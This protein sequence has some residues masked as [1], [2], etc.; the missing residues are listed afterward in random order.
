MHIAQ[1]I[2]ITEARKARPSLNPTAPLFTQLYKRLHD[3][4]MTTT[5]DKKQMT[6]ND[7]NRPQFNYYPTLLSALGLDE[8]Q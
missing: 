1:L 2:I 4:N 5:L 3:D 7:M 6:L 8:S